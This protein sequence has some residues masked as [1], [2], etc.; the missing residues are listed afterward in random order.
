MNRDHAIEKTLREY[1]IANKK[2][3]EN[4]E[5]DLL[6]VLYG[7]ATE[8]YGRIDSAEEL[9]AEKKLEEAVENG[10]PANQVLDLAND[11]YSEGRE[12]GFKMGFH[13][14]TKLMTEGLRGFVI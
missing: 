5:K 9:K 8:L 6:S 3:R 7:F 1:E 2:M 12:A 11:L 14:A 13:M 10:S 4:A